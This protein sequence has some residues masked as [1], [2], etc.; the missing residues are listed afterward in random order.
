MSRLRPSFLVPATLPK[1]VLCVG[2]LTPTE[3]YIAYNRERGIPKRAQLPRDNA[4][5]VYRVTDYPEQ[6]VTDSQHLHQ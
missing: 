4:R 1:H 3:S 5:G 2:L 6:R